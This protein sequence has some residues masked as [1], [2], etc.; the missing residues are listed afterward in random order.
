MRWQWDLFSWFLLY[1]LLRNLFFII[2]VVDFFQLWL[3]HKGLYLINIIT[4]FFLTFFINN[5]WFDLFHRWLHILQTIFSYSLNEFVILFLIKAQQF[6]N[7]LVDKLLWLSIRIAKLIIT[8]ISLRLFAIKK[9]HYYF[10]NLLNYLQLVS[11]HLLEQ[12][13]LFAHFGW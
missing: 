3:R 12:N 10:L 4:L 2:I 6:L 13:A 9:S 8:Q 7:N 11:R 1:I 5:L